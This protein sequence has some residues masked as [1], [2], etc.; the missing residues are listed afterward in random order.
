MRRVH[1]LFH[2]LDNPGM[3][4]AYGVYRHA[5]RDVEKYVAI[6]ILDCG[7]APLGKHK[8]RSAAAAGHGFEVERIL[9]IFLGFGSRKGVGNHLRRID[10]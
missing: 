7:A 8:R 6:R 10:V 5:G 1:L 4:P 3:A 9:K 2:G